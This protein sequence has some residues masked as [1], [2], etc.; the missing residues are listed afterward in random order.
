ML[1]CILGT[2]VGLWVGTWWGITRPACQTEPPDGSSSN[3]RGATSWWCMDTLQRAGGYDFRWVG[4]GGG[5]A[6]NWK[7]MR[8]EGGKAHWSPVYVCLEYSQLWHHSP[9]FRRHLARPLWWHGGQ[10]HIWSTTEVALPHQ[11]ALNPCAFLAK[12]HFWFHF[13]NKTFTT[14]KYSVVYF[15]KCHTRVKY[16]VILFINDWQ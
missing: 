5:G 2:T 15:I 13:V 8:G 16:G 12:S 4:R 1:H 7:C 10:E 6:E 9:D 11:N 3:G 14:T